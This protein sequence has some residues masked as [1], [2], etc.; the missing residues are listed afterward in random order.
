MAEKRFRGRYD[1]TLDDKGRLSFPSRFREI[2]RQHESEVLV[3]ISWDDHIR[4][5]PLN[6]WEA[7]ENRLRAE[8][9]SAIQDLDRVLR[10]L[11]SESCECAVDKQGRIL[12]PPTLRADHGLERDVVLIG[13]IDRV[14]IWEKDVWREESRIGREVFGEHKADIKKRGII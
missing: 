6:E 11:E 9:G 1:H 14:E 7:L 10:H 4:I 8:D 3:A 5:Y 2:L 12:L 13:M